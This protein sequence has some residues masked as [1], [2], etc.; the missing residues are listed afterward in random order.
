MNLP[1]ILRNRRKNLMKKMES[2][3]AMITKSASSPDSLLSDKNLQ[4]LSG[5]SNEDIILLLSPKGLKIDIFETQQTPELG[6]G[7]IVNE[8]LFLRELSEREKFVDGESE[9]IENVKEKTGI[10]TIKSLSKFPEILMRNLMSESLFWGNIAARPKLEMPITPNTMKINEICQRF[11]WIR[12]QNIA[13][14]IHQMRWI[15]DPYEIEC[16]RHAFQIHSEIFEKIMR[17]LTPGVNE[18][19][20]KAIYD[21]EISIRDPKL[22][23]GNWHDQYKSNI[24]IAAGKNSA[25]GH[26]MD[27]NQ[28]IKDGDLVLIDGG[29]EYKGYSSDISRTFPANGKFTD[30][31]KE[32]YSIVLEAQKKAIAIMKPGTTQRDA[33]NAVYETFKKYGVDKYGYGTCGHP[34]GLNIHDANSWFMN[35]N[36]F[37]PG[38]VIVIE[39]FITVPEEG[40]GIRIEDGVLITADGVEILPGPPKEIKEVETLCVRD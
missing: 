35:D 23:S 9:A 8:V 5:I 28:E 18:S 32:L 19:L 31:Q 22:V 40:I 2:G 38:V 27:N 6:R 37:E 13:P 16:L 14:L 26:Y 3:V 7:R 1:E 12:F 21:Y 39:P 36:P 30:R 10:N 34:V 17:S 4:Y 29:V 25:I 24:I 11:P 15:K 20:G 33:H